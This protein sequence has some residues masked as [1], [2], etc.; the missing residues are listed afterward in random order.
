MEKNDWLF[1]L[2]FLLAK[3]NE[4]QMNYLPLM[5]S[6]EWNHAELWGPCFMAALEVTHALKK[7][8]SLQ[9]LENLNGAYVL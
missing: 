4:W 2:F 8:R 5:I 6:H 3:S 7:L 9:F 1:C